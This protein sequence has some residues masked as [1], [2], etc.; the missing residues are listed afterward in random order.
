M[1]SNNI[2]VDYLS[3]GANRQT[4]VAD[5]SQ[6]GILAFGSDINVAIWEPAVRRDFMLLRTQKNTTSFGLDLP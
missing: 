3:A 2:S 6:H 5:W 1:G 4:A